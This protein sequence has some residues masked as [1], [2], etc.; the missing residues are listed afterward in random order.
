MKGPAFM[1]KDTILLL[2]FDLSKELSDTLQC[3]LSS[4]FKVKVHSQQ[5][6]DRSGRLESDDWPGVISRCR[7][8]LIFLILPGSL[9]RQ[10]GTLVRAIGNA[11]AKAPLIIVAEEVESHKTFELLKLG[12]VDYITPPLT[13]IDILPRVG[14][15][16]ERSRQGVTITRTLKERFGLKQLIGNS[17]EFLAEIAKIPLVAECDAGVLIYGETGTGKELYARAIHYLSPRADKPF[18]PINCGAIPLDLIENELFGHA[19]GAF[20]SAHMSQHGLLHEA[21]GGTLFLDEVDCLPHLAQV[22]LLRF[23]QEQEYRPL[24]SSKMCK[25]DVRII[26]AS[27]MDFDEAVGA[28]KLRRDFYY[29]LNVIMLM[30]PPLRERGADIPRLA[31]HFLEKYAE[32][33]GRQGTE[34]LADAMQMLMLYDWPGNVRELEHVIKRAT[35]LYGPGPISCAELNLPCRDKMDTRE[36][37]R[38]AKASVVK[39]FEKAYLQKLLLAHQG[40]ITRAA[41]AAHK[42]RRAFWQLIRKHNIDVQSFK[43][44]TP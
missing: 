3:V 11:S 15:L 21:E 16:L 18:V 31:R 22:K 43:P 25:A 33:F 2:D 38:E 39:Q 6:T 4:S 35:I 10:E 20:T 17:P 42:N 40:N 1:E 44:S 9:L 29:R 13:A 41:E 28:G 30:L 26:A 7:P 8:D 12:A 27:N 14:R 24:G 23:L 37:F 34:I 36:T 32:E 19:S 5:V